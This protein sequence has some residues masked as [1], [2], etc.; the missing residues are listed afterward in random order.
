LG[1]K[2]EALDNRLWKKHDWTRKPIFFL[3]LI[4]RIAKQ[5]DQNILFAK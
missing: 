1:E 2:E 4:D 5:R 3:A